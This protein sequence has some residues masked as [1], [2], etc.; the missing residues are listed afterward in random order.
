MS[1]DAF[2]L[3]VQACVCSFIRL[4][5]CQRVRVALQ[6]FYASASVRLSVCSF[7]C[8]C[9]CESDRQCPRRRQ[10]C[11]GDNAVDNDDVDE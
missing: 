4:C 10:R 9:V 1:S 6:E 8:E 3:S 5:D 11:S 2:L 7:V